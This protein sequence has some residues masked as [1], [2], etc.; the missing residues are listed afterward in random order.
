MERKNGKR[1]NARSFSVYRI[2][3]TSDLY[4]K[5]LSWVFD[6]ILFAKQLVFVSEDWPMIL[7]QNS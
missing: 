6:L 4:R 7:V 5:S 2:P 3:H 1:Y